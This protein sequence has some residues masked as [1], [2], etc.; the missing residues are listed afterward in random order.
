MQHNGSMTIAPKILYAAGAAA[1]LISLL[2]WSVEWSGVAYVCPYCR[3]QRTGMGLLGLLVLFARPGGLIV[4]WLSYT[5]N[6][7]PPVV[8]ESQGTMSPPGRANSTNRPNS[9]IPV[10]CTRQYGQT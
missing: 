4:P 8:Y 5:T 3:V 6:A 9:P 7:K 2:A 1:V 10:R